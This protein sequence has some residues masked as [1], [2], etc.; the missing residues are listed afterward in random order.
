MAKCPE[1]E[2]NNGLFTQPVGRRQWDQGPERANARCLVKCERQQQQFEFGFGLIL[3]TAKYACDNPDAFVHYRVKQ[4]L[5]W[6]AAG[7]APESI[8]KFT[9][10]FPRKQRAHACACEAKSDAVNEIGCEHKS[11][12]EDM[13]NV[14]R[15]N[16]RADG[17]PTPSALSVPI[18]KQ[19]MGRSVFHCGT[20]SV[21]TCRFCP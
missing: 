10:D 15:I 19:R 21:A 18:V 12:A 14:A 17:S 4:I 16:L 5:K 20:C 11:I 7:L 6:F 13:A 8:K 1:F 2:L 3:C 9:F